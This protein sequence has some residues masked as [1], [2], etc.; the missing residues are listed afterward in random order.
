VVRDDGDIGCAIALLGWQCYWSVRAVAG[1]SQQAWHCQGRRAA[2]TTLTMMT[3]M[4]DDATRGE[5]RTATTSNKSSCSTMQGD[6]NG[7]NKGGGDVTLRASYSQ[8]AA[9]R[10]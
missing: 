1:M 6:D 8:Q 9:L 7:G 3:R 5:G 4:A 2:V 10:V